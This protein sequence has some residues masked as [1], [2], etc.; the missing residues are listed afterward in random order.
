M[1]FLG[2]YEAFRGLGFPWSLEVVFFLWNRHSEAGCNLCGP[3]KTLWIQLKHNS[4][5]V[6]RVG[7]SKST[8]FEYKQVWI[9]GVDSPTDNKNQMYT[10]YRGI[11]K[12][13]RGGGEARVVVAGCGKAQQHRK[14]ACFLLLPVFALRSLPNVAIPAAGRCGQVMHWGAAATLWGT[15]MLLQGRLWLDTSDKIGILS[16]NVWSWHFNCQH[17]WHIVKACFEMVKTCKEFK[18]KP[19]KCVC[20]S[21]RGEIYSLIN[22]ACQVPIG[23]AGWNR[24]VGFVGLQQLHKVKPFKLSNKDDSFLNNMQPDRENAPTAGQQMSA[25]MQ[26][27]LFGLEQT[28]D[29]TIQQHRKRYL[30]EQ[31]CRGQNSTAQTTIQT[32]ETLSLSSEPQKHLIIWICHPS[33]SSTKSL[34]SMLFSQT[35]C[36]SA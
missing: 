34:Y 2:A 24:N 6:Q 27:D 1:T 10:R 4:S 12:V 3:W 28:T 7:W 32:N 36:M 31:T 9:L 5:Q 21:G 11:G 22:L 29:I 16:W 33:Q 26:L 25:L 19:K 20:V 18:M 30:W 23:T 14:P 17:F 8:G 35:Y 15:M 13:L